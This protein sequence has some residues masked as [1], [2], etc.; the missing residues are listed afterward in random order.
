MKKLLKTFIDGDGIVVLLIVGFTAACAPVIIA[1]IKM[2][3]KYFINGGI[4]W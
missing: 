1:V 3:A 2:V 4:S